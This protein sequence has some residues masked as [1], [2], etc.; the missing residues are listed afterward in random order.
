MTKLL[1]RRLF[2]TLFSSPL[3]EK[4]LKMECWK[5]KCTDL[6]GPIAGF[7]GV[8][9]QVEY[10]MKL[11]QHLS[12]LFVQ[13]NCNSYDR[14][15]PLLKLKIKVSIFYYVNRFGMF[16]NAIIHHEARIGYR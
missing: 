15:V 2:I 7:V 8:Q 1:F 11:C 9:Q 6:E 14:K 16:L 5:L 3:L 10:K 13:K 4:I 12:M